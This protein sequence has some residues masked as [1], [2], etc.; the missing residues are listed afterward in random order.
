MHSLFIL[1]RIRILIK[2]LPIVVIGVFLCIRSVSA[3]AINTWDNSDADNSWNNPNNWSLGVVPDSDDI[4]TFDATSDTPCNIDADV[5]VAGFDIN[6]GYTSTITQTSTYTITVGG[7]GFLQDVGTFSGGSG[8]I[9]INGNLTLNGASAVFNSTSGTLQLGGGSFNH[10]S[11][12]F[13][14][15]S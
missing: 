5:N 1:P 8:T 12:T 9:D 2:L 15:S 7:N 11:G 3:V 13:N 4:A 10:T 14:H 6:T